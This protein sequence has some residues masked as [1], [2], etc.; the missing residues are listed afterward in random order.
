M[1]VCGMDRPRRIDTKY[2]RLGVAECVLEA[3]QN[4]AQEPKNEAAVSNCLCDL[5]SGYLRCSCWQDVH[6]LLP[7]HQ[8]HRS[9]ASAD[10]GR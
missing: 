6:H 4:L 1:D 3:S 8:F 9:R 10:K 5:G 2:L 7:R